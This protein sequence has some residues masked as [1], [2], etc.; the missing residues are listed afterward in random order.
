MDG[1]VFDPVNLPRLIRVASNANCVM[2]MSG[3]GNE[4][5]VSGIR[6]MSQVT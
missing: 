6:V 1:H 4:A 3:P 2:F 5:V